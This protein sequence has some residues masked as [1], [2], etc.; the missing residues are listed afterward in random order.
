MNVEE[1]VKQI[2]G[3]VLNLAPDGVRLE[4][5]LAEDLGATSLDRYTVLMDVEEA[6]ALDLDDLSEEELEQG[7]RTVAD[8][9]QFLEQRG[10]QPAGGQV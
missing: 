2:V 1:R 4:A 7:I 6:F 10:V 8:I 3:Q 5:R 9:V